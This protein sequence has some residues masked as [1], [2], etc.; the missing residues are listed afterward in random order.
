MEW[1]GRKVYKRGF[2]KLG[3]DRTPELDVLEASESTEL[4]DGKIED[5]DGDDYRSSS[6][7]AGSASAEA[8]VNTGSDFVRHWVRITHC[9]INISSELEGFTWVPATCN[10]RIKGHRAKKIALWKEEGYVKRLEEECRRMGK[11]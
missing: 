11:R 8:K 4:M 3:E 9:A 5:N 2:W 1:V 7:G 10:G 6:L